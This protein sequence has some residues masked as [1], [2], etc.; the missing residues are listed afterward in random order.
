LHTPAK[1]S[2]VL[3]LVEFPE[4]S[5]ILISEVLNVSG[6]NVFGGSYEVLIPVKVRG[7]G[8]G[9]ESANVSRN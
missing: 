3:K 6:G 7:R 5:G 4:D 8:K 2:S 1:R 9:G